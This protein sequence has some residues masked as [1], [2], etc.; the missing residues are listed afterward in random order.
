MCVC[1]SLSIRI[2]VYIYIY[3][4]IYTYVHTHTHTI[5]D[6]LTIRT[7]TNTSMITIAR[8]SIMLASIHYLFMD[9]GASW[10][11]VRDPL[12][13]DTPLEPQVLLFASHPSVLLLMPL[14]YELHSTGA[15][16]AC[17]PRGTRRTK[18]VGVARAALPEDILAV[19]RKD[20]ARHMGAREHFASISC[21]IDPH[22]ALQIQHSP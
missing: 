17:R 11:Y 4:H 21:M 19:L 16:R 5:R 8:T 15:C 12:K 20:T 14:S 2:C 7:C 1:I 10:P 6:V 13:E 9:S 22:N 3:I 18:D